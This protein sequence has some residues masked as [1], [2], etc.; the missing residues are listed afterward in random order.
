MIW[1]IF[2]ISNAV[3]FQFAFL[4]YEERWKRLILSKDKRCYKKEKNKEVW[5]DPRGYEKDFENASLFSPNIKRT[6]EFFSISQ[7]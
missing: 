5:S 2:F 3:P 7:K 6:C 1:F 4:L